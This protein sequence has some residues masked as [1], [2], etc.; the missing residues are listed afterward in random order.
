MKYIS[1]LTALLTAL[2][3]LL[4]AAAVADTAVSYEEWL[5][6][7]QAA[8]GAYCTDENC[9]YLYTALHMEDV[10]EQYEYLSE[11]EKVLVTNEDGVTYTRLHMVMAHYGMAWYGVIISG[12]DTAHP[13]NGTEL[14][15]CYF[16]HATD[17]VSGILYPYGD[18]KHSDTCAWHPS[19]IDGESLLAEM[20][21][22][23]TVEARQA[24]SN[25]LYPAEIA[26]MLAAYR[27]TDT[28]T[29]W[30]ADLQAEDPTATIKDAALLYALLAGGTDRIW[31]DGVNLYGIF[32]YTHLAVLENGLLIDT[33]YHIAVAQVDE[34]GNIVPLETASADTTD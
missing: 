26:A 5:A 30:L 24:Y 3:L 31:L 13:I 32:N 9:T 21:K 7:Q 10:T 17:T 19:S 22:L 14:C 27:E 15:T 20:L 23:E 29:Q 6:A 34:N 11:L 1:R 4:S 8:N 2:M 28:V 33:R 18:A 12:T 25:E 16:D